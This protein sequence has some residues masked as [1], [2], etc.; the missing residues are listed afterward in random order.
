[1]EIDRPLSLTRLGYSTRNI[2]TT[3]DTSF[4]YWPTFTLVP[5][6]N[7]RGEAVGGTFGN[8]AI[9]GA[10]KYFNAA[11]SMAWAK[12][13]LD[14]MAYGRLIADR[15]APWQGTLIAQKLDAVGTLYRRN[16]S[17]D[18]ASGRFTQ[19]DPIGL[20]GGMNLYGYAGGD[21]INFSDPFGLNACQVDDYLC[22]LG[23]AGWQTLG[24]LVGFTFGGLGGGAVGTVTCGPPHCTVAGAAV[25]AA[26]GATAGAVVAGRAFDSVLEMARA[27]KGRG[28]NQNP[29]ADANRAAREEGL[30]RTGQ[31]ALHDEITG[32]ELT[33][34]EIREIA[35]RLAEQAKYLKDPPK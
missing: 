22:L 10:A 7:V 35:K 32:Q 5:H 4:Y 31:R 9:A 20:A 16:R 24:G 18:P 21:P 26:A 27:G 28:G 25:G 13:N 14:G 1:L 30:N 29:N 6:W 34:D 12:W 19:E 33:L 17:Y 11:S 2:E 15:L 8:G 23:R 3:A